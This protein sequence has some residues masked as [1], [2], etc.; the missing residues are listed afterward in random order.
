MI[1]P[2]AAAVV[3][4]LF[5]VAVL[6]AFLWAWTATGRPARLLAALSALRGRPIV[7]G[8]TITNVSG[9]TLLTPRPRLLAS[10]IVNTAEQGD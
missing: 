7:Y 9:Q 1:W 8:V 10:E 2:I 3:A 6:A 4:V 5:A